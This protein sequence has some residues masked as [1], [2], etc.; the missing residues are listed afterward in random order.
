MTK[1]K[2]EQVLEALHDALDG[3]L[4]VPSGSLLPRNATLPSRIPAAGV[5]IL[6]DGDP[7]E[8]EVTLSPL[9]YHYEHRAEVDVVIDRPQPA[10]D[11]AF[12]TLRRQIG[13]A[14]ADDR[15]LGGLCEWVDGVAP[16]PLQLVIEGAESLKAATI[17]VVLHYTADDPL[18]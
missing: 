16:A 11:Q 15:T 18:L 9:A 8:P 14:V 4:G 17:V 6:R 1:S 12:D 13:A 7:G 10:A 2:A 5:V 3:P